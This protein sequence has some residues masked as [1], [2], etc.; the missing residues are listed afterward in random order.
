M[1]SRGVNAGRTDT[2]Q[3]A[4]PLLLLWLAG[5]AMRM[6]LLAVPP[7]VPLIH[8]EMHLSE[9]Q[10]GI[11]IGLPLVMFAMAAVP[12]TLLIARLGAR[13]VAIA[14]LFGIAAAS[15]ARGGASGVLTL[16]AATLLLGFSVA[17]MQPALPTLV[18]TWLPE[19]ISLGNAVSTNGFL[20][21]VAAGP[22]LTIPFV[23][24]AVGES[25]RLALVTWSAPVLATA[26][27]FVLLAPRQRNGGAGEAPLRLEAPDWRNPSIWL[28]GLTFGSNNAIYFTVNAFLPDLLNSR[29]D[30]A[31]IGPALGCMNG[32]QLVASFMMMAVAH[33][34]QHRAW[35]YLVFGP[36]PVAGAAG[37]L[38]GDGWWI[39]AAA[40]VV[41]F[42]LAITFV[43]TF[44]LPALLS[45]PGEVHRVA[46]GMFTI[47]YSLAL[48]VPILSG[49][50]WDL[51][52]TPA[53]VFIPVA[54]CGIGLTAIGFMLSVRNAAR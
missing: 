46:G 10:V 31:W 33:R 18:R 12:G 43:V 35:P 8:G 51:T 34:M 29:G 48:M 39:V 50:L 20:V 14:A 36:L 44:A 6:P 54:L 28:L 17:I 4:V 47:S 38:L 24:P 3:M 7:V 26:V 45:P 13:N 49:A 27:L 30:G 52:G 15:T 11:L 5:T 9:T 53:T 16:Y 40:T 1:H 41:G 37:I 2:S 32:S 21:G 25:W 22:A 23:L 19:R 42:T